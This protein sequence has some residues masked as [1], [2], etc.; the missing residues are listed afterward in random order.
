MKSSDAAKSSIRL[1]NTLKDKV[2]PFTTRVSG[3]AFVYVCGITPY[4]YCHMGHARTLVSFDIL[5]RWMMHAGLSVTY[6]QN[7]TDIDDKIIKRAKENKKKGAQPSAPNALSASAALS[8]PLALSAHF[9]LLSREDMV[10]LGILPPTVMPKISEHIP[11]TIELIGKIIQHNH[12]YV[13]TSGVYFDISSFPAYGR[14]SGQT[15]DKL[16]AGARVEVNEDKRHPEDFALW[17]L[18]DPKG[19]VH[20]PVSAASGV[21]ALCATSESPWGRGRPGWHIECSAMSLHYTNGSPLDLH[22]GARDLIFPHHE[23]EIAQSEGAGVVPFSRHW[24]HTG[25]LT[26]NGEKMAKSLGNFITIRDGLKKW[27]GQTMR[28]F[29][30]MTHYRS[31]IDFSEA[32]LHSAKNAFDNVKRSLS[33]ME[34]E[35][36]KVSTS[37]SRQAD[38]MLSESIASRLLAF[39]SRMDADLDTPQGLAELFEAA[40]TLARA[41]TENKCARHVLVEN[42]KRVA[43][44]FALL[45]LVV[46]T[47]S[48]AHSTSNP[49]LA[50]ETIEQLLTARETAR[51]SK[52]YPTADAIRQKLTQAGVILEDSKEGAKWRYA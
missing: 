7:V 11:Q 1:H 37:S 48:S 23:N 46:L 15:L 35:G 24:T 50:P 17:K 14:L 16:R 5:R 27:D 42:A 51:K 30:A 29:F 33:L 8:T 6:I 28:L 20:Q 36:V 9:D 32:A 25:F 41:R 3:Q 2:E 31:P 40:K 34:G 47:A 52:D 44:A 43:D 12:A 4:D 22:G 13:T 26:V 45:G 39:S 19:C 10:S 21:C 38:Q 49:R 18:E